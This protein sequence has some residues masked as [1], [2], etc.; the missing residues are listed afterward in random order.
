[1]WRGSGITFSLTFTD[2]VRI[3]IELLA[4]SSSI[5]GVKSRFLAP[6]VCIAA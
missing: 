6:V 2:A 1:M 4:R 5:H 3:G